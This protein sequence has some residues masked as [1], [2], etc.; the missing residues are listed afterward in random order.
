MGI[1]SCILS[2]D[3]ALFLLFTCVGLKH[4]FIINTL[5]CILK[6]FNCAIHVFT[7]DIFIVYYLHCHLSFVSQ[8][9]SVQYVWMVMFWVINFNYLFTENTY[10]CIIK[11][12]VNTAIW[13]VDPPGATLVIL[14]NLGWYCDV[15]NIFLHQRHI[16]IVLWNNP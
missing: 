3:S 15:A 13:L 11:F 5:D 8:L 16:Q 14:D 7:L 2:L 9:V 10:T 1:R 6:V 12:D 4:S